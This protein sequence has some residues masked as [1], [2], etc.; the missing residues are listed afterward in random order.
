MV[1]LP[2]NPYKLSMIVIAVAMVIVVAGYMVF[3]A[4]TAP[5]LEGRVLWHEK[6]AVSQLGP[7]G[8]IALRS[9]GDVMMQNVVTGEQYVGASDGQLAYVL[10]DGG[11]LD[12]YD[13]LVIHGSDE[14][15]GI[16]LEREQIG[17]GVESIA[18][19]EAGPPE[20]LGV[21][22]TTVAVL[23]CF[24]AESE[25]LGS[26]APGGHTVM[27]GFSLADGERLWARDTG[28]GCVGTDL[29]SPPVASV[30]AMDYVMTYD[31]DQA[32][33]TDLADGRIAATWPDSPRYSD[34][35]DD[36]SVILQDGLA[37][38]RTGETT[39]EV[40]DLEEGETL[41]ETSCADARLM[42]PGPTVNLSS[43]AALAVECG[44]E[45]V[46][47]FERDAQE[48]TTIQA[49]SLRIVP[50]GGSAVYD[51]YILSRDGETVTITDGLSGT[52]IGSFSAPVE[53]RTSNT[54]AR[55][56][57]LLMYIRTDSGEFAEQ[58]MIAVDLRTADM[59]ITDSRGL[60]VG[61]GVDPS[62]FA[63]ASSGEF[64]DHGGGR[65]GDDWTEHRMES[66][67]VGVDGTP[68]DS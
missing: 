57:V 32:T 21:S 2:T 8:W 48:F 65:Y 19:L 64:V 53:M 20:I 12:A 66:W 14:D 55:G 17:V 4:V 31:G 6:T 24:A 26:E 11:Y 35:F 39:M 37:L 47:V 5:S 52:E 38:R 68:I 7:N 59:L 15:E 50:D 40:V 10:P 1:S 56:R 60:R 22:E 13:T 49:P 58:Q 23:S 9:D 46:R 43:E 51:K 27:A 36:D 63:L 28:Q 25:L 54:A 34:R 42:D 44:E 3:R 41:A 67:L 30:G 45:E 33:V 62:G 16:R 18:G 29:F 61:A